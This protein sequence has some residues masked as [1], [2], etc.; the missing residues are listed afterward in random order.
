MLLLFICTSQHT[1][2]IFSTAALHDSRTNCQPARALQCGPPP[3]RKHIT[4]QPARD[5]HTNHY[6]IRYE[7]I[8]YNIRIGTIQYVNQYHTIYESVRYD[9]RI[10][11]IRYTNQYDTTQES[12]RYDIQIGTIRYTNRYNTIYESVG[13]G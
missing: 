2:T 9:R 7:L 1:A 3:R 12:V 8:R 4:H 6:V 13:I 11:T 5:Q 10:S